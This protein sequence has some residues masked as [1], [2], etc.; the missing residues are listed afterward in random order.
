LLSKVVASTNGCIGI[1]AALD[2]LTSGGSAI[3]AV[4]A[5]LELVEASPDD[6]SVG[7]SGLP[8]MLGEVE[9]DASVMIGAGLKAGSVGALGNYQDAARLARLVMEELP[10]VLIVGD[11]AKQFAAE[12]GFMEQDLR[13]PEAMA[14][15]R[16]R[17]EDGS[18]VPLYADFLSR[19]REIVGTFTSD[20]ELVEPPHGTVNFICQDRTGRIASG[21]S[22]SGWAWKYPGRV[23]DSPIIGAG[24]YADDR[25]GAA[26]CTGR[27]EMAQRVCT[28]HSVVMFMR[29]GID[30]HAA[31]AQALEDLRELDDPFA[32]EMNIVALSIDG[33]PS[34]GSTSHGRTFIYQEE[35]M[36]AYEERE[37]T[38]VPL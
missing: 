37:R 15:W 17:M 27:G 22:S 2:V 30:V 31:V 36:R 7:Y 8:N 12:S 11:G 21:V 20:P 38:V 34:A 9:L 13:T 33:I 14:I 35:G 25:F 28:A 5:G 16:S 23:G 18:D 4:V 26:T 6:H 1:Q 32:S 29:F 10:H 24:N 3:D 19:M